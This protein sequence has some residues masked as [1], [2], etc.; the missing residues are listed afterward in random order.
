MRVFRSVLAT[1]VVCAGVGLVAQQGPPA[2]PGAQSGGRGGGRGQ[3][4][5]RV[6]IQPGQE[7]PPGMTEVRHLSC[8]APEKPAPSIVDYRPTST[9]VATEHL[10]PKAKYPVVDIHNHTR[11][12]AENIELMI[13]EMDELNLRVLV[14]LTGGSGT[15]FKQG[16]DLIRGSKYTDRFR[17]FA[18]VNW[19]GAGTPEWRDKEVNALRQAIKDGAIGLK[20]AKNLGLTAKKA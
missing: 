17:M 19:N 20:I 6:T 8:Q 16:M 10:V 9:L 1:V 7:C 2:Q 3:G 5:P 14:N 11:I 13:K 15:D 18:L 4:A 12:T